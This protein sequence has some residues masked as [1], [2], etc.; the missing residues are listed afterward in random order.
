MRRTLVTVL[1][2]SLM[3]VFA[4]KRSGQVKTRLIAQTGEKTVT[5]AI[6]DNG[7]GGYTLEASLPNKAYLKK[8]LHRVHW[9]VINNTQ[10]ATVDSA[11]IDTFHDSGGHTDPF[12]GTAEDQRFAFSRIG[13]GDESFMTSNKARRFPPGSEREFKYKVTV[14]LAGVGTPITVDPVVVVGE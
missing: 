7:S 10:A 12:E 2:L 14:R 5:I 4:C 3:F 6:S 9:I 1:C 11:V 8:G 13:P